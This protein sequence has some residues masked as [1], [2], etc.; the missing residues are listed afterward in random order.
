[1]GIAIVHSVSVGFILS[2]TVGSGLLMKKTESGWS[3]PC[4]VGLSGL[5]FGIQAGIGGKDL[6]IFILDDE[7]MKAATTKHGFKFGS[8]AELTVGLG[9]AAAADFQFSKGG[10]GTTFVLAYSKGLFGGLSIEGAKLGAREFVNNKFYH[11][12]TTPSDILYTPGAVTVPEGKV[13]ML[14]EVYD[15][16]KKL[17][18]GA[19]A[20]KDA[21]EEAKEKEAME[22]AEKEAETMKDTP[23]VEKV[24]ASTSS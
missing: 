8:Q 2:G 3:P 10:V 14:N 5:G 13:T 16:L 24:D 9:R 12:S 17:E 1:V 11:A 22:A 15:K 7:T 6:V 20:E 18:E 23:E 4:A 19:T 21:T